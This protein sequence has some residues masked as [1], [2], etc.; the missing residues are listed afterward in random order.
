[1]RAPR[2][3]QERPAHRRG[4]TRLHSRHSK[5]P[6]DGCFI[7][8]ERCVLQVRSQAAHVRNVP[9][10]HDWSIHSGAG[11]VRHSG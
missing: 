7:G 6:V 10:V 3:L 9:R 2:P 5:S 8:G 4:A 1:M 11:T